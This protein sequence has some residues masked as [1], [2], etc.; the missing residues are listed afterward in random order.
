M[1]I[2]VLPSS[3]SNQIAAGEVVERPASVI[4]ECVENALDAKAQNIEIYLSGGGKQLIRI[5]DDGVGMPESDLPKAV[6]RHATSKI[7]QTEDLFHLQQYGFRGEALA[8]VSS[9]S[10]FVLTSRTTT[11]DQAYRLAGKAGQFEAI[12]PEA[13][14]EGT[15]VLIE[16]LFAPV[17]ARL[18]YLKSD[19]A[20]YRACVK[21]IY[22]FALAN[23]TVSFQVFKEAKLSLDYPA[24]TLE[25][26]VHQVLKKAANDLCAVDYQTPNLVIKGFTSQPGKG[27]S[28]KNQQ[29]LLVNGRRIEDHRLAYAVREAYVQSAG[30]EK[31]LFPAFV[32]HLEIDPILVDVNVHPRKLEVKFAEPG[33][34]FGSVKTAIIRALESVSYQGIENPNSQSGAVPVSGSAFQ[35][36]RFETAPSPRQ[37]SGGNFF[38]RNLAATTLPSFADRH[39]Q[40][41]HSA[42]AAVKF[43]DLN[44]SAESEIRLIGQADNKYIVAQ[45]ASG[46]YFFDQHALHE[47]QRFETFWQEYKK[48]SLT[49]QALLVPDV[50]K[51]SETE[52]SLLHEHKAVLA[53]LGFALDFVADDEIAVTAVAEL[54]VGQDIKALLEACVSFLE[55]EKI[56][57]NVSDQIMRKLLEYKACRGAVMFGDHLEREEMEK[58]IQDFDST[59]WK[60][61]C[62]HGRPNHHFV[63]FSELDKHFHR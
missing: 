31:H 44:Q 40:L 21:E 59:D 4:K 63:P 42:P 32:L 19:E 60:L 34:V 6:L 13:A 27:L 45:V 18:E 11:A 1:T 17:P 35:A 38:N 62:P 41:N 48:S 24:T 55:H 46:I 50:I 43:E 58:L 23:P 29:Y 14:N 12:E 61:L 16:N 36:P 39:E 52:V 47:R 37:I 30:I 26:R 9:V 15:T 8:A 54:L 57:E 51:L 56:G 20:E 5:V 3:I 2:R 25:D 22:G 10:D 7:S 53:D 49:A 28:N 33:E